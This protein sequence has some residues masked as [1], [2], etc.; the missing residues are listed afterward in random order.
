MTVAYVDVEKVVKTWLVG[1]SVGA[2]LQK[3]DGTY[4]I[5]IG[6]LA[7]SNPNPAL[8][9]FLVDGGPSAGRD[10]PEQT[11]R[12]QFDCWGTSRVQSESIARA[13]IIE[14]DQISRYGGLLV[15]DTYLAAASNPKARW[16]PDPQSDTPRYVV[17]ALLIT[18]T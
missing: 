1:N 16:L 5:Y 9:L 12:I 14:L 17:D 18:V 10:L 2:G 4:P 15:G 6:G 7:K 11:S 8:V 13:L 3:A